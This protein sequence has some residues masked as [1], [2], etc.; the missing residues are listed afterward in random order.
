MIANY[1]ELLAQEVEGKNIYRFLEEVVGFSEKEI[2]RLQAGETIVKSL[3]TDV[4]HEVLVFGATYIE[5]RLQDYLANLDD[6]RLFVE[7]AL[8]EKGQLFSYPPKPGDFDSLYLDDLDIEALS[9]CDVGNCAIKLPAH[10]IEIIQQNLNGSDQNF[11]VKANQL[12]R[13]MLLNYTLSY[14]Q[15]GNRAMLV[16]GDKKVPVK[17]VDEFHDLLQQTS[18]LYT[19]QPELYEYL[20]AYPDKRPAN[21]EELF[22]WAKENIGA[23]RPVISLNHT[24]LYR[25]E[26]AKLA[27]AIIASKQF[28]A[29]HYFEASLGITGLAVTEKIQKK[30]FYLLY[31]N[32]SRLDVLRHPRFGFI[33]RKISA[34]IIDLLERKITR[35]K[36]V[37]EKQLNE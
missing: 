24:V 12:F 18:F 32:R 13:E 11:E 22:F 8:A 7:S 19:Y 21:I 5:V 9:E 27:D 16:Y 3:Q 20:E 25:P 29:S 26:K 35:V 37:A 33:K 31:L 30:G 2:Y 1:N 10:F 15:K 36:T 23:K 34:G 4:K 14:M 28:Y 17:M 6:Y